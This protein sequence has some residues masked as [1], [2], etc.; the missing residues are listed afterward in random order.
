MNRPV[1]LSLLGLC[2][3][4]CYANEA[5]FRNPPDRPSAQRAKLQIS[6]TTLPGG[7]VA[8]PY[9][10]QL[11]ATG[12]TTP[13]TWSLTAGTLPA[14]LVLNSSTGAIR[15]TPA[16]AAN[17]TSL[18]F[19]VTDSSRPRQTRSVSLTLTIS[20]VITPLAITT[21]SLPSGQVGTPYSATLAATGGV[22]PYTWLVSAGTLP[23]GITLSSQGQLSGTPASQGTSALTFQWPIPRRQS[24]RRRRACPCRWMPQ[25]AALRAPFM[26]RA[27]T[28]MP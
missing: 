17:A 26:D 21:T 1:V 24:E 16:V 3:L 5:A 28:R 22:T 15:G 2:L 11:A 9:S 25:R 10:A 4:G 7:T 23:A 6:T 12:G 19:A 18:T 27:S 14:N 20:A 13:Y 8:S